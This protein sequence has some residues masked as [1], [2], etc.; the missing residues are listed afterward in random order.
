MCD[1]ASLNIATFRSDGSLLARMPYPC[2]FYLGVVLD[3]LYFPLSRLHNNVSLWKYLETEP[4][5]V[6][7]VHHQDPIS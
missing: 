3:M 7:R 6:L 2:P 5:A 4:K 1:K